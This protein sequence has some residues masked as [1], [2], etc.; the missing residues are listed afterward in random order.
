MH[1][2]SVYLDPDPSIK[3][4]RHQWRLESLEKKVNK[5]VEYFELYGRNKQFIKKQDRYIKSCLSLDI[6]SSLDMLSYA[7][8]RFAGV[9]DDEDASKFV[10]AV[11]GIGSAEQ[12]LEFAKDYTIRDKLSN[13][14]KEKLYEAIK[15]IGDHS[16]IKAFEEDVLKDTNVAGETDNLGA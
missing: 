14:D 11:C 4:L 7:F 12:L 8:W 13:K 6:R 10:D 9:I 5:L 3:D 16:H 15:K 2:Y 1:W